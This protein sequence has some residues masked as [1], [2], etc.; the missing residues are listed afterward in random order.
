MGEGSLEREEGL[1]EGDG[2]YEAED[3][4]GAPAAATSDVDSEDGGAP[5]R[6]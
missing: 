2:C 5:A 1:I 4:D 3:G 6:E